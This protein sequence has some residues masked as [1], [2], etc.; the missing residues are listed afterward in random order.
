M[1]RDYVR[2]PQVCPG[3]NHDEENC[4]LPNLVKAKKGLLYINLKSA[5]LVFSHHY[6]NPSI[7]A[8]VLVLKAQQYLG[9]L[10]AKTI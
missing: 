2:H 6:H 4:W 1:R 8:T 9:M 3:K 5:L 7:L 10:K